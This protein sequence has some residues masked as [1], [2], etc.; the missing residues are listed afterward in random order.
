MTDHPLSSEEKILALATKRAIQAAGGIDVCARETGLSTSQLSRC[1]SPNHRDSLTIRDA[2]TIEAIGDS[3]Q[4]HIL[5]A[6]ARLL[7]C[8]VV[9]MPEA[10]ADV[11]CIAS[12]TMEL[13]AELGD[14]AQQVRSALSDGEITPAEAGLALEHLDEL[15]QASAALRMKLRSIADSK[16]N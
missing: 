10:I 4:P 14:F 8:V 7:N 6:L 1:N 3:G 5:R 2:H 15:D 11:A 9:P 16:R 12:G 13:T